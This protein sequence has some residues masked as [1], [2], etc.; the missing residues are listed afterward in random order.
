[1][2]CAEI[3]LSLIAWLAGVQLNCRL[4]FTQL[5]RDLMLR[6]NFVLFKLDAHGMDSVF[7]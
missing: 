1:M 2:Y 5:G 4:F 3:L 7:F 6:T